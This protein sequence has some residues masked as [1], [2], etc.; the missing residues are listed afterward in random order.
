M[1]L[2]IELAKDMD[3]DEVIIRCRSVSE[4]VKLLQNLIKGALEKGTELSLYIGNSQYYVPQNDILFFETDN[5]HTAAHT[6]GKMYYTHHK[7]Y[8]LEALLPINFVCVS[9]SC[10]LNAGKICTIHKNLA[11]ASEVLFKNTHKKVYVSRMYY[12]VLQERIDE[13]RSEN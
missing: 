6:V 1:K 13:M 12:K 7:L 5:G 9:K 4:E 8:E 2:R 11:G 10:I 3:E